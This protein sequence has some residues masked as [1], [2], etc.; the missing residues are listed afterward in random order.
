MK[1][2]VLMS[3][4]N[5]DRYL[6][7]AIDSILNQTFTDFE[8]LIINDGSTDDT[9]QILSGYNDTRIRIVNNEH[10][11][12]LTKSL[13]KGLKISRGEYIA[14]MDADD[15]SL[16][17]RFEKQVDFM[18]THPEV[19]VCGSW[20]QAYGEISGFYKTPVDND[21]ITCRMLFQNSIIHPSVIIR[22]AIIE[23][24]NLAYDEQYINTQDYA[25]WINC[26]QHTHL[27]NIPE[28]LLR[29]RIHNNQISILNT[30]HQCRLAQ[31]IQ[32]KLLNILGIYPSYDEIC[33]HFNLIQYHSTL[34]MTYIKSALS[35]INRLYAANKE[36]KVYPEPVFSS[37]LASILLMLFNRSTHLGFGTWRMFNKS[38]V[39]KFIMFRKKIVLFFRHCLH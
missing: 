21:S 9:S 22:K 27:A 18:E 31:N 3:V 14:R 2:T 35:W 16:P 11:I 1:I 38:P 29:L 17:S 8:F 28:V 34:D 26:L 39:S 32:E 24:Y 19:G 12:G 5:A 33:L 23:K 37:L 4:F 7:S 20:A 30:D 36:K 25:F 15:I 6:Q 13:N 10:N